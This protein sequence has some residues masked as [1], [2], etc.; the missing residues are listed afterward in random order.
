M[1]GSEPENA[2]PASRFRL[3]LAASVCLV[4]PVVAALAW[5]GAARAEG[6]IVIDSHGARV[7]ERFGQFGASTFYGDAADGAVT[8]DF[9]VLEGYG[10]GQPGVIRLRRPSADGQLAS[11]PAAEKPIRLKPPKLVPNSRG[12]ARGTIQFATRPPPLPPRRPLSGEAASMPQLALVPRAAPP[13]PPRRPSAEPPQ[14]ASAPPP[15]PQPQPVAPAPAATDLPPPPPVAEI[16]P[17]LLTPV[18]PKAPASPGPRA[19][20][21]ARA[22][23]PSPAPDA[24]ENALASAPFAAPP[25]APTPQ[26]PGDVGPALQVRMR[27]IDPNAGVNEELRKPAQAFAVERDAPPAMA[28]PDWQS[29]S[30]PAV[31]IE[32][33]STPAPDLPDLASLA[34]PPL[35]DLAA[36]ATDAPP[37]LPRIEP[38]AA[39]QPGDAVLPPPPPPARV[40]DII[41]RPEAAR[42]FPQPEPEVEPTTPRRP[43]SLPPELARVAAPAAADAGPPQPL[44]SKRFVADAGSAPDYAVMP[45]PEPR[46]PAGRAPEPVQSAAAPAARDFAAP[47]QPVQLSLALDD[48]APAT[49][50]IAAAAANAAAATEIAFA[51][52]SGALS[53][54]AEPTLSRIAAQ[55]RA[56]PSLS[57][58]VSAGAAASQPKRARQLAMARA[59]AVH[60]YLVSH[61]VGHQAI[62]VEP[63]TGDAGKDAVSVRV[64]APA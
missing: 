1:G 38:V 15:A 11:V 56:D 26:A 34:P 54:D 7:A 63:V 46:R 2:K 22:F 39:A 9:S 5:P 6:T 42:A 61:G 45:L 8:L 43:L 17:I 3:R 55:L 12:G 49:P 25:P 4:A 64:V 41:G 60:R 19:P 24:G 52:A 44:V 57:V 48:V 33:A 27:E 20:G 16:A 62:K 58:T 35:D 53:R 18:A 13:L 23:I 32:A 28:R 30:P 51:A 37:V 14:L 29:P 21:S 36:P 31:A 47:D 40:A 10:D 59:I 50:E